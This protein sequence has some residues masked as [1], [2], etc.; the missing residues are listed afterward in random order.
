MIERIICTSCPNGCH[1]EVDTEK[2]TVSGNTCPRGVTY[3]IAEVT[4]PKRMVTSTI[5]LKGSDIQRISV[6]TDKPISKK[7]IFEVMK[8]L[9]NV[10][11]NA[12]CKVGDVLF[13]NILG[14]DVNIVITKDAEA[15]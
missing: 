2:L 12:P 15:I 1:L 11:V 10:S 3:G 14:T 5:I 6:K 13:E 7:L 9:D 4:D 8:L